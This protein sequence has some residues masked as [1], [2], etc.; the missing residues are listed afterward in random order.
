MLSLVSVIIPTYN[1]AKYLGAAIDSALNQTYKNI[2]IIIIDDGSTDETSEVL[3]CY[4]G[5]ENIKIHYQ[6]NSGVARTRN[7]GL[8]YASGKYIAFLD[9][10]DI[11]PSGK[12]AWQVQY[13]VRFPEITAVGG[14]VTTFNDQVKNPT[15]PDNPLALNAV[16]LTFEDFFCGN[17][18]HSPGQLLIRRDALIAV[19]GFDINLWGSDDLDLYMR[20]SKQGII[21]KLEIVSLLY[22]IHSTNAS[23]NRNRMLT[24]SILVVKKNLIGLP[25][26]IRQELNRKAYLWLYQYLG[27]EIIKD[28]KQSILRVQ[29][30]GLTKNTYKFIRHFGLPAFRSHTLRK[31]ILMDL[32]PQRCIY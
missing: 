11:W 1:H 12:T 5:Y 19:K 3:K 7:V 20:L 9:D 2:E 22:R 6:N 23:G 31:K 14:S 8:Q 18:F 25:Q 4:Q 21:H 17:P 15:L 29:I 24:N 27:S 16:E 10:D 13:L 30:G 26:P 28:V 32:I